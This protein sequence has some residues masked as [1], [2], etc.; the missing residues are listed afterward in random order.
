MP[1]STTVFRLV[2]VGAL[3]CPAV[4]VPAVGTLTPATATTATP[5]AI[6]EFGFVPTRR[7]SVALS[8]VAAPVGPGTRRVRARVLSFSDTRIDFEVV[9]G[10]PGTYSVAVTPGDRGAVSVALDAQFV[11]VLPQP[12]SVDPPSGL[13]GA[14]VTLH[15]AFGTKGGGVRIGG[16]SARVLDWAA[17]R[18]RVVVPRRLAVGPQRVAVTNKSGASTAAVDFT[19]TGSPPAGAGSGSSV[20]LRAEVG[21]HGR[22]NVK[23]HQMAAG[24]SPSQSTITIVGTTAPANPYVS[25]TIT[26]GNPDL[27]RPTPYSVGVDVVLPIPTFAFA[28]FLESTGGFYRAS[29]TSAGSDFTVTVTGWDGRLLTGTFHGTLVKVVDPTAQPVAITNGEFRVL[30]A[31]TQ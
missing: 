8:A 6:T 22:V 25:L 1:I 26:I 18:I 28:A 12:S 17:D 5:I 16:K 19:V 23:K 3:A 10:A 29:T 11:L 9:R 27:A 7:P 14:T 2:L 31:T 30:L 21:G 15:G 20:Y 24:Y 4:A 13:T